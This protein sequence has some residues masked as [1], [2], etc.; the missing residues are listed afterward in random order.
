MAY[1]IKGSGK[2]LVMINGFR[3]TTASWD[4]ALLAVLEKHYQLIV[5]DNRGSG[6]SSD[7]EKN[8]T[9]MPQMADDVAGLIQALGLKK[10]HVLGWSMGSRIAQ[11]LAIQ[12]PQL[13]DKLVLCATD[14]GGGYAVPMTEEVHK[15]TNLLKLTKEEQSY[16]IFPNTPQGRLAYAK[17]EER[18]K[19]AIEDGSIP[20]DLSTSTQTIERQER[21]RELWDQDKTTYEAIKN[22]QMPVL[23]TDGMEDLL[24]PPENA[25]MVACR[26]PFAWSA[27]FKFTGHAF[28]FQEYQRFADLVHLFLESENGAAE[29]Q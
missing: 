6:L 20:T 28:L 18:S 10:V 23:V 22:I 7:T 21:A 3:F 4:P 16:L 12:H 14:P 26:I 9:T 8:E 17:H 19:K 27:Y 24:N 25:R 1:Y 15:L 13:I 29:K 2:P 11:R 5:F